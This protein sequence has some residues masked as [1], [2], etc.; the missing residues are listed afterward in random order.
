MTQIPFNY[1]DEYCGAGTWR[2]LL[3]KFSLIMSAV[4]KHFILKIKIPSQTY[5][6]Y[7]ENYNDFLA[8]RK[9]LH[10]VRFRINKIIINYVMDNI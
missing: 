4:G 9:H 2:N 8:K 6:F 5:S 10:I 1:I 7:I 3:K